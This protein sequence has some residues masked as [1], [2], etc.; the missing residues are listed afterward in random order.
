VKSP[1]IQRV[2]EA[3][4]GLRRSFAP[5]L[6]SVGLERPRMSELRERLGLDKSVA[7][8]MARAI[9]ADDAATALRDLPRAE[10]LAR[11][12]A[13]CE[14]IGAG[15]AAVAGAQA[16]VRAL[17]DAIKA[18]PGDRASLASALATGGAP[19][20][21]GAFSPVASPARLRAAR[22]GAYD[23][24][25]FAQ[26]ISCETTSCITILGPGHTPGM[27]DQAMVIATTG[28]RRLRRGNPYAILSLQG[29]PSSSE[30]YRRTAL[31][32]TPLLDDPAVALM[33]EFCSPAASQLRLERRGKFHSLVLD[34]T[35]P[36][37]D[38]P[39]DLA[40]GVVNLNFEVAAATDENRWTMTQYTVSRACRL[41]VREVLLHRDTFRGSAPEA[42]FSAEAVPADRPEL[43]GPDRSGRG[44]V[45][46]G[47]GFVPMGLG[48]AM[49]ATEGEDF[50]VPM[51][52]RA[53]ELLGWNPDDF[54]RF[55]MVIEYPLPF[56]R[57]EV[58]LRLPE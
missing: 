53:F 42:T 13:R 26:G 16:A 24:L 29:H 35:V 19:A 6:A 8:R 38:E 12:I 57:N 31:S 39:M 5:M 41:H 56:V 52:V 4:D 34:A 17:D 25:L 58:W 46:H 47:V 45:E 30:G 15:A 49:R 3:A 33:P 50:V 28:L 32:G 51:G 48:F 55:R 27:L 20:D 9:R 44:F 43:T 7:S 54:Q 14:G 18:F 10:M 1:A 21:A 22:R 2:L 36:P 11:F 37:L 23:A 40:Y